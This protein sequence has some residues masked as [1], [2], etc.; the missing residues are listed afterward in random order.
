MAKKKNS[1]TAQERDVT[2]RFPRVLL[3]RHIVEISLTE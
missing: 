1:V 2:V 3:L